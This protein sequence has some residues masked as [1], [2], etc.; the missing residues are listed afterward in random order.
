MKNITI[1]YGE[2]S[3]H[4]DADGITIFYRN[5]GMLNPIRVSNNNY[6]VT[7]ES[8][9]AAASATENSVVKSNLTD[10]AEQLDGLNVM[11]SVMDK[12]DKRPENLVVCELHGLIIGNVIHE[13]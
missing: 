12:Y 1:K 4:I 11:I 8:L 7:K 13:S 5:V 9:T 3:N 6:N 2:M 10:L